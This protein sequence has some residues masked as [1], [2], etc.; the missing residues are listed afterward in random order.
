MLAD[1]V[2]VANLLFAPLLTGNLAFLR[3]LRE[4][5][6]VHANH[7]LRDLRRESP[8]VRRHEDTILTAVNLFMFIFVATPL[9][10]IL[11]SDVKDGLTGYIDELYFIVATLTTAGFG[12]ITLTTPGGK[13]LS[14]FI[15]VVGAE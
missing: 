13:L 2:V 10:F 7:L 1:M 4:V 12:D 11:A 5:H 9:G 3:V 8:F 14:V 15:M 6:L